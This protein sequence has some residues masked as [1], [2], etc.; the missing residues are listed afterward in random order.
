MFI[1]NYSIIEAKVILLFVLTFS[2]VY[3]VQLY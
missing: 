2:L 1:D 3:K